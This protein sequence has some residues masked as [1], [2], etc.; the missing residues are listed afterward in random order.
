MI[1][2]TVLNDH[3]RR[4]FQA[5]FHPHLNHNGSMLT[6]NEAILLSWPF[7]IVGVMTNTV[8]S[9]YLT[10]SLIDKNSAKFFPFISE[11]SLITFPILIGI[12]W[13][14]WGILL[15]PLRSYIYAYY[16]KLV[17][18]FYQRI[19]RSYSADPHLA[20][21][22]VSAGMSSNVFRVIPALGDILQSLSQFLCLY[23]GLK[24]RMHINSIA[25]FCIL[26]TPAMLV[27]LFVTGIIYSLFLLIFL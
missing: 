9:I 5:L 8:F 26:M 15:F 10:V 22:I 13:S 17:I 25:A 16:I 7:I 6:L 2:I 21:D 4:Y 14:I 20:E 18:V 24:S 11:G 3:Y 27:F 1:T 19:T 23:K 12:F